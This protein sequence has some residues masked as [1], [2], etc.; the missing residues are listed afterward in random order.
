MLNTYRVSTH[1]ANRAVTVLLLG[2][3]AMLAPV[4]IASATSAPAYTLSNPSQNIP[5]S[6][7]ILDGGSCTGTP[8]AY[9]CTNP[10]ITPTL[11]WPVFS[12]TPGC[13]QYALGAINNARAAIGEPALALPSNWYTLTIP[14]QLFVIA[15]MERVGD[16]YPAYVGINANLTTE[17]QRA[18]SANADPG[19]ASGFA[20]GNNAWGS[21][22]MGGAWSEGTNV[23]YADYIWMYADGW[24][25]SAAQTSNIACTSATDPGCWAH[26]DELLGAD[27]GFNPGV[28]LGCRTCEMGT[29]YAQVNGGSSYV[30]LIELP[31]ATPPP[32]TFTWASEL[33]F[34]P[35]SVPYAPTDS[36]V[37]TTTV[38]PSVVVNTTPPPT[39]PAPTTLIVKK[40]RFTTGVLALR[41]STGTTAISALALAVY[42]D[43]TCTRNLGL[44]RATVH[45]ATS[46]LVT[47]THRK[48]FS[49][50]QPYYVRV[51]AVGPDNAVYPT[52]CVLVG[53]P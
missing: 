47:M 25:G 39:P 27:P 22:G 51:F 9:S 26:R 37:T 38:V 24:G 14:E 44:R 10:C 49:P 48:F 36:S 33:P 3:A 15:D 31:A 2:A 46:G 4:A 12:G 16:G 28:G 19:L 40:A 1:R 29:G 42:K 7:N 8:G 52:G 41:W 50:R 21:T 32:T 11:T 20:V 13:T 5:S 23:L 34:F 6:P 35:G 45:G 17:A 18:A 53:R 30:D 43:R